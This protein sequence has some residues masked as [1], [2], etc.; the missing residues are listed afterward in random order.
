MV[1]VLTKLFSYLQKLASIRAIG[2]SNQNAPSLWTGTKATIRTGKTQFE[3]IHSAHPPLFDMLPPYWCNGCKM[4]HHH[5]HITTTH[6]RSV[7]SRSIANVLR[8][9]SAGTPTYVHARAT[10]KH[11]NPCFQTR[12]VPR[13]ASLSDMDGRR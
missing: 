10:V 8:Q 4:H 7:G 13:L 5:H 1:Q 3:D 2:A 9:P 12:Q 11:H 6:S